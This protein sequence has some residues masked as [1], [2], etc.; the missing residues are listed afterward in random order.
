MYSVQ[1]NNLPTTQLP[2]PT[3]DII[4]CYI[5]CPNPQP[6][7]RRKKTALIGQRQRKTG[8]IY[9]KNETPPNAA[10]VSRTPKI[11]KIVEVVE[12]ASDFYTALPAFS[13][14]DT[15]F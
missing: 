15:R 9:P 7:N 11:T 14:F 8:D 13:M 1:S 5:I 10:K 6:K 3:H 2:V 4:P 12:N